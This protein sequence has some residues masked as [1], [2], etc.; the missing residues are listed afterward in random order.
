MTINLK[1]VQIRGV[2]TKPHIFLVVC[3]TESLQTGLVP[4]CKIPVKVLL[5]ELTNTSVF[6]ALGS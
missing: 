6:Q 3:R 1:Q 4:L 5:K 2:F